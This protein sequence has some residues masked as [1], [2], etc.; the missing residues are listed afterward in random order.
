MDIKTQMHGAVMALRPVGPILG[1]D[2]DPA[3]VIERKCI[4]TVERDFGPFVD[5]ISI[6]ANRRSDEFVCRL[7]IQSRERMC[8]GCSSPDANRSAATD[9]QV[10]EA[11][12]DFESVGP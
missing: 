1:D 2:A 3:T 5:G 10:R 8:V 7:W 9:G 4:G 6:S 12:E 11:V